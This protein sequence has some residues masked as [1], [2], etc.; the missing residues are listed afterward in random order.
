[1]HSALR[2]LTVSGIQDD[3][4][5]VFRYFEAD[6]RKYRKISTETTGYFI[7]A[8]LWSRRFGDKEPAEP[9]TRAGRFL[10][11][12]AFDMSRELF[13]FEMDENGFADL[14]YFFDCGVIIRGLLQLSK[15]TGDEAYL[16]CAERCG[17]ALHSRMSTVDGGFFPLYDLST[18]NP[19][20]GSGSWSVEMDVHHLKVR[21]ALLELFEATGR[22]EFEF[23]AESLKKWCL[24][25]QES[26]LPGESDDEKVM[27]R[28]HA[29]CCF[30]E[31]LLPDVSLDVESSRVLQFG[32][33]RVE[34]FLDEISPAFQR[35]DTIAQLLRLRLYADRAGIMELDYGRAEEEA[36]AVAEF[37]MQSSD[38]KIDG[39]FA[40]ARREG[41]IVP[42]VNPA[43]TAFSMQALDM[44]GQAEDGA[45]RDPWQ[46]LI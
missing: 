30:L 28:L 31:G 25:R 15:A 26:F 37:Q 4:G 21:L 6:K 23:G 14:A 22:G 32:I 11:E 44:W 35:C 7:N 46:V 1:M 5:G 20:T 43:V 17:L 27:D 39:G 33:L 2:W 38:P 24:R 40:F 41:A 18:D 12:R 10:L 34:N 45:F 29:Y 36:V 13:P 3:S 42:H 9:A 16:E 19:Q 8:L